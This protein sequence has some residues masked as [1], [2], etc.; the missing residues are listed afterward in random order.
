MDNFEAEVYK[1]PSAKNR[2]TNAT[3]YIL[4]SAISMQRPPSVTTGT[5]KKGI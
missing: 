3:V 1:C 5:G 4:G 2:H